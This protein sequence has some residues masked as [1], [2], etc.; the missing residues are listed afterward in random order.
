MN[1]VS[2]RGDRKN[3]RIPILCTMSVLLG[4]IASATVS[5][6]ITKALGKFDA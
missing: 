5:P 3:N 1:R 6:K 2:T 4:A